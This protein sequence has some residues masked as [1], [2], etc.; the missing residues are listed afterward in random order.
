MSYVND[1]RFLP[2]LHGL[3]GVAALCIVTYHVGNWPGSPLHATDA[4]AWLTDD[5][6]LAVQLFFA[7]SALCL[8]HAHYAEAGTP[9]WVRR[10]AIRRFF[11]IAPLF[12]LSLAMWWPVT[13]PS[14]ATL[15]LQFSFLFSLIPD[16]Y[17]SAVPGGWAIGAEM[18]FYALLPAVILWCTSLRRS[19]LLFLACLGISMLDRMGVPNPFLSNVVF[20]AAGVLAFHLLRNTTLQAGAWRAI[21][22]ASA[23][24]FVPLAAITTAEHHPV[25]VAWALPLA[26]LCCSQV[27][28]PSG[29]LCSRAAQWVGERSYSL[30]LLHTWV[31]MFLSISAYPLIARAV[32]PTLAYGAGVALTIAI[33]L[34][35]AWYGHR[36]VEVPGM[37]LG[38]RLARRLAKERAMARPH[39]ALR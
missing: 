17:N 26:G 16:T 33:A 14:P 37:R 11:R 22:I 4:I 18:L 3:R 34:P 12:Y 5:L 27:M 39:D 20:F 32:P 24:S 10:F 8:M 2:G 6:R 1:G 35:L 13:R 29:W 23:I 38:S 7:L 36:A 15:P 9:G 31:V 25:T 28:A 30:Y 19:G 21:G